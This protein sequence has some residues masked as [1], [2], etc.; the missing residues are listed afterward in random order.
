MC[1]HN[2]IRLADETIT[3]NRMKK[4]KDKLNKANEKHEN[5]QNKNGKQ[6][7]SPSSR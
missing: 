2:E 7:P 4:I 6:N 3:I 5:M 1:K